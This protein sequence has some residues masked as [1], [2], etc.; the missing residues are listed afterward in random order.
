MPE[1]EYNFNFWMEKLI[2]LENP[3]LEDKTLYDKEW[4]REATSVSQ[5]VC[6]Q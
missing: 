3:V 6:A 4:D 1:N 5:D 2:I